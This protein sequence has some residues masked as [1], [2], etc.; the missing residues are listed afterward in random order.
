MFQQKLEH[1]P[2]EITLDGVAVAVNVL[3]DKFYEAL[4]VI[5]T[6]LNLSIDY[7]GH[8]VL[9]GPHRIQYSNVQI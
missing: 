8:H 3:N 7:I 9:I 1:T 5:F 2:I 4:T 6:I